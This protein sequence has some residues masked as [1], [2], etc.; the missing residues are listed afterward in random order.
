MRRALY[1]AVIY[2]LMAIHATE[3]IETNNGGGC[4]LFVKNKWPSK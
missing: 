4:E 1:V 2:V 3:K